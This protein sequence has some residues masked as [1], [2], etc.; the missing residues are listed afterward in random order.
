MA[1]GSLT[2]NE[3]RSEVIDFSVPFV[4]TG[5]SV[6]VSRSNG[7]VSPSA[8]LGNC[9]QFYQLFLCEGVYFDLEESAQFLSHDTWEVNLRAMKTLAVSAQFAAEFLSK[10]LRTRHFQTSTNFQ[11]E[12][13]KN[14]CKLKHTGQYQ[15]AVHGHK[16]TPRFTRWHGCCTQLVLWKW[17]LWGLTRK[18]LKWLLASR[19]TLFL[20]NPHSVLCTMPTAPPLP[21]HT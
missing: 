21:L 4:E 18:T 6:M 9:C 15:Y 1:V 11:T 7:T 17:L 10:F 2:I 14:S 12:L 13:S 19:H 5:I 16:L 8:F 3:E 20:H